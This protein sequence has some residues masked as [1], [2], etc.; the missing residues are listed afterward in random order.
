VILSRQSE[1]RILRTI[2]KG[3]SN[4]RAEL[5]PA[6]SPGCSVTLSA[7]YDEQMSEFGAFRH[8]VGMATRSVIRVERKSG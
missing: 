1:I 4:L 2:D 5:L 3:D 8:A 7:F 6:L